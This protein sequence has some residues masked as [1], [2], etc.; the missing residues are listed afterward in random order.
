MNRQN[1]LIGIGAGLV[2]ALVFV[3]AK[4][5]P[6]AIGL[7]LYILTP[8]P[9]F[10]AG[11]GWGYRSA[12][13]AGVSGVLVMAFAVGPLAGALFAATQAIPAIVLSY[14]SLLNRNV[15]NVPAPNVAK[16]PNEAST[17]ADPSSHIEWYP[18]GRV[19]IWA[20]GLA[21]LITCLMLLILA[22]DID[23]LRAGL[24]KGLETLFANQA[25]NA[26]DGKG[27]T[28]EKLEQLTDVALRLLPA[29][30]SIS[31]MFGLLFNLWLA[32]RITLASGQLPRP[33]PVL[34][35][36][37][38]PPGTSFVLALALLGGF[39]AG[40]VG[41]VAT[42]ISG[43]FYFAF[44]LLGLAILHHLTTGNSWRPFIL[45]ATY[46]LILLNLGLTFVLALIGLTEPFSPLN[47]Q[48]AQGPPRGTGPPGT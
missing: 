23:G 7:M 28:P 8:L 5:S 25:S 31:V 46:F 34:S 26:P 6:T 45:W 33:W 35:S 12:A 16:I 17:G 9:F 40:Y 22:S 43:A 11:L 14:L 3:S 18:I 13:I 20:A 44:V 21:S 39:V 27:L 29:V 36:I 2:A 47:R 41:L 19:V 38:Y 1:S 15:G 10:L 4:T 32:G 30:A 42:A 48:R 24:K 37:T